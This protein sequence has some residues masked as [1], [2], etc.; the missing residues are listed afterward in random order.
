MTHE[1]EGS[2][3]ETAETASET[4]RNRPK[5]QVAD[6]FTG[7]HGHV[8]VFDWRAAARATE[9]GLEP[10]DRALA[11]TGLAA[12]SRDCAERVAAALL[13]DRNA[14]L[15]AWYGEEGVR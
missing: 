13:D 15:R 8:A 6:Q 11:A 3:S 7:G 4:H 12:E 2:P 5:Q 1:R 10:V 14:E 9:H